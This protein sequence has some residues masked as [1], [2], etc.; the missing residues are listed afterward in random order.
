MMMGSKCGVVGM[1]QIC[2]DRLNEATAEPTSKKENQPSSTV[3]PVIMK[4]YRPGFW[5]TQ[6][7]VLGTVVGL[8][9][10]GTETSANTMAMAV[11]EACLNP[12]I[13]DKL[14]DE[15]VGVFPE[16]RADITF[17]RAEK[18]PYLTAFIKEAFRTSPGLPGRLPRVVKEGG[19]IFNEQIIAEG[20]SLNSME[21]PK[22]RVFNALFF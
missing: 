16:R 21:E 3:L 22:I 19:L 2:N 7:D 15:L 18:L 4:N 12:S 1:G 6:K 9:G 10:G 11:Y 5:A 8:V 13:Q 20:V 14:Y 17:A